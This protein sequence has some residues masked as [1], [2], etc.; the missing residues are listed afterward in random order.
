MKKILVNKVLTQKVKLTKTKR[1]NCKNKLK[2]LL[3]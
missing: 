1:I 3:H 2:N